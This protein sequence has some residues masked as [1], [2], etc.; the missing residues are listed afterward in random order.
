MRR[1][2]VFLPGTATPSLNTLMRMH[3]AKRRRQART[4][5]QLLHYHSG[6]R[7]GAEGPMERCRLVVERRGA[8]LL[9]ADNLEGGVKPL[10][11]AM[12]LPG[13]R[14]PYGLGWLRDDGPEVVVAHCVVQRTVPRA[15]RGTWV[16]LVELPAP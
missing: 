14:H 10:V 11:D 15:E 6:Y 7:P 9:D 5:A 1:V 2:E 4:F 8:K 16:E 3:W 13:R 12:L